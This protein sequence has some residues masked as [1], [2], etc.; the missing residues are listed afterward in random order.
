VAP[1]S[2]INAP[3]GPPIQ[4]HQLVCFNVSPVGTLGRKIS[5]ATTAQMIVPQM[6]KNVAQAGLPKCSRNLP[7]AAD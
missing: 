6:E 5:I 3:I 7:F 2:T 4:Y 1:A